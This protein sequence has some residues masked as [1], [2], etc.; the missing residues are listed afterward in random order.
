[1]VRKTLAAHMLSGNF[2]TDRVTNLNNEAN[3]INPLVFL[4]Q[5]NA[6][7][8]EQEH[9]RDM[10]TN[11]EKSIDVLGTHKSKAKTSIARIGT[12]VYIVDFSSLC[13]NMDS[14]IM[15]ITTGDSPPPILHQFLMKFIRIINNTDTEW[16][17]WYDA[18]HAHMPLIHWHCYSFLEEVFNHIANFA[19]NFGNLNIAAENQSISELIIQPLIRAITTMRAFE[20]NI[21]LYQS[22]GMPIVTMASSIKAYTL[23][24]W[25]KANSCPDAP[26]QP[27]NPGSKPVTSNGDKPPC[28]SA[29]DK[30]KTMTPESK[31][32]PSP[33]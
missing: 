11:T 9:M 26:H 33:V 21:I 10:I 15:A 2:A 5:K 25:N 3:S 13:I 23:T 30:H 18:T 22:L 29:G 16:A 6:C 7:M 32:K 8:I 19:T 17:Q 4:P 14:I 12:M 27:N 31:A 28:T 20:D 24:S 1:M